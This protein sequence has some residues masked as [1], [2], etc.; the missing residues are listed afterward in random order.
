MANVEGK[1]IDFC[2]GVLAPDLHVI[3][4]AHCYHNFRDRYA[5]FVVVVVDVD[6]DVVRDETRK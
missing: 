6:V 1:W 3:T 2:G 4:A 5:A